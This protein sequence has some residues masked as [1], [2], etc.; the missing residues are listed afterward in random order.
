MIKILS[1][2]YSKLSDDEDVSS[3][4]GDD[5]FPNVV[6]DTNGEDQVKFPHIVMTR[7]TV[8]TTYTKTEGCKTDEATVE[9]L[10]WHTSYYEIIDLADYVR[11]ALEFSKGEVGDITVTSSHF[12]SIT[13]GF[14]DVAYYQR[15]I[16]TFK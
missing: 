12:V 6:P 8:D 7:L 16:F 9:V 11:S 2:V 13:E 4:V 5:I 15:L 1:Y 14:T 3:M 10:C